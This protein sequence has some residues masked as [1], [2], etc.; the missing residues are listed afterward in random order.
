MDIV[1]PLV[2]LAIGLVILIYGAEW[3]VRGAS[4]A[5]RKVG[6]SPLVVGLTVVAFGTSA[7][8]LTVNLYSALTGT[9]DIAVG[10]IIGSNIANILLIL[11]VTAAI[12][13]LTVK[14]T[15]VRW[16]IPLALLAAVL[17]LVFGKDRLFGEGTIDVITRT[18]GLI[19]L[20]FFTVFMGYVFFLVHKD[21]EAAIPEEAKKEPLSI[22]FSL[23]LII[24]GFS[25]LVIGGK[26]LVDQAVILARLGGL[27]EAVIGLTIVAVGTSLPE[28]ATSVVA[29]V[30]KEVDI[31]IGNV[32][33]SNIFNVFFVL[34][35]TSVVAPLPVP[36]GFSIDASVGIA[37]VLLLLTALFIG[38]RGRLDRWQGIVFVLLYVSYLTYLVV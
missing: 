4:S 2:L 16:G 12:I 8:E 26:M 28:L 25:G 10:N 7:P 29:A 18:D 30:K 21:K 1:I 37:A 38:S 15:T 14:S 3:L 17:V 19:L 13:P 27:S 23:L 34:G 22:P 9:T 32:I 6:I 20:A 35:L 5:A 11:G 31:A 24:A 33:G 36:E